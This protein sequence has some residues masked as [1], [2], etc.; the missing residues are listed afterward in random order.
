M[1]TF[2]RCL[3]LLLLALL[4]PAL[5]RAQ[6]REEVFFANTDHELHVYRISGDEP[7]KTLMIIGGI[8]GDEP[9]GYLTADLYA[10]IHLK[11]GNLIVVPRANFYSILLS[12][13]NGLTG[14][15][16][17][18]FED[19][20]D[21]GRNLEEEVVNILKHL[22]AE[23]DC[24][25]NLHEGS[26]FYSPTWLND[27]ENPMRFGQSIIFDTARYQVPGGDRV[28]DL[29]ALAERIVGHANPQIDNERYRFKLNNHNTLDPKT[30]HPEQRRSATYYALTVAH[31][32]AF[33]I[34]TSKTISS[35]TSKIHLHKLMINA[36]LAT[37]GIE[38]DTPGVNVEPPR[39]DYLLIKVNDGYPYALPDGARLEVDFGDEVMVSDIIANYRRGVVA[40]IEG[41]GGTN[42]TARLFRVVRPTRI[43]IRKDAQRCGIVEL[44]PR[45][46]TALARHG[47]GEAPGRPAAGDGIASPLQAEKLLVDVNGRMLSLPARQT[48]TVQ[49]GDR[50]TLQSIHT[51]QAELDEKVSVNFKGF[52]PPKNRNDGNDLLYPIFTDQD[53]L[54]R[55]SENKA[56]RRYPIV[57]M[58]ED[59]VIGEFWVELKK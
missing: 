16:N 28:I 1:T 43:V 6:I 9:G 44:V 40:D 55:F 38:P 5:C 45:T 21:S 53:L 23:S 8:Q 57:A 19:R 52:A 20:S 49:K 18:K 46:G 39:L 11:R 27:Q 56:G 41:I 12:Q 48:L 17:R 59:K 15:M 58:Y 54:A 14:D 42:D 37:L 3:P 34:E 30:P 32:P 50:L 4:I 51:N 22:I 35:L 29:E 7:G 26:G 36:V 47:D 2:R 33:G 25:V 31:I 13:R 10:D 24:L